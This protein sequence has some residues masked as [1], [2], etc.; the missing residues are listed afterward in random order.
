MAYSSGI[1]L[2]IRLL[3]PTWCEDF[4]T[5]SLQQV[6]ESQAE[7]RVWSKELR[8]KA[9][10]LVNSR[11]AKVISQDDYLSNRKLAHE[12]AAECQRRASIL[13]SQVIRHT[14]ASP[15]RQI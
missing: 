2:P 1:F 4:S 12:A 10:A 6:L 5:F 11:L 7:N 13:H 9:N 14:T 8:L 3:M 15:L